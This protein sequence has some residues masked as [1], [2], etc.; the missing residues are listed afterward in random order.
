[1][2]VSSN[3]PTFGTFDT[4]DVDGR[5]QPPPKGLI[6]EILSAFLSGDVIVVLLLPLIF[7]GDDVGMAIGVDFK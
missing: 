7:G 1:M 6:T 5:V 4:G 3:A 2:A